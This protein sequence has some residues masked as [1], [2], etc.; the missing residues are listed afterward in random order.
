MAKSVAG[1]MKL[2]IVR[3]KQGK[4]K[5][6]LYM[7]KEFVDD[8]KRAFGTLSYPVEIKEGDV[9]NLATTAKQIIQYLPT[10]RGLV[11]G[12]EYVEKSKV[13]EA[14]ARLEQPM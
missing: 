11:S 5:A 8:I 14:L 3:Y 13:L 4:A 2:V 6:T 1:K 10:E 7:E 9:S 12:V